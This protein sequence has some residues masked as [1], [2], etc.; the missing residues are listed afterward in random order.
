MSSR[1]RRRAIGPHLPLVHDCHQGLAGS[2]HV[3]GVVAAVPVPF[4]HPFTD[5]LTDLLAVVLAVRVPRAIAPAGAALM[6]LEELFL[7]LRQP[8]QSAVARRAGFGERG[9]S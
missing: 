2:Q 7:L 6:P 1:R 4:L 8:T 5:L 9:A 3:G